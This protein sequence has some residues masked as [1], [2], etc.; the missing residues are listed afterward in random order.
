MQPSLQEYE[1]TLRNIWVALEQK[2]DINTQLMDFRIHDVL[3][4][5]S[6]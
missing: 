1:V 4:D 6:K 5:L 2:V 3:K